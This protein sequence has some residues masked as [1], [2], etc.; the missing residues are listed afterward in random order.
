MLYHDAENYDEFILDYDAQSCVVNK[1]V[2]YN[3][4]ET[5]YVLDNPK[6]IEY[7]Y[8]RIELT[9]GDYAIEVLS[10]SNVYLFVRLMA[11]NIY[12]T[13]FATKAEL[14]SEISQ[15]AEEIGL[16]V[17]KKLTNYSTT[18]QMNSAIS[19]KANEITSSVSET[20][21]TKTNATT[22]YSK[23]TQTA[24]SLQSQISVNDTDISTIKQSVNE[25]NIEVGKKYNTSDFTNAKITA[26]IND[27]TSS[28]LI[29]AN[30]IN[31]SGYLTISSAS[32]TY[33][34]KSGL[35]GGTTTI[36]GNC[37]T[38]GT[39]DASKV[40]VKNLNASN[41][42]SGTISASKIS[43]GSLNLTGTSTTITSTNF[44]VDKNGNITANSGTIGGFSISGHKL[45]STNNTAGISSSTHDGNPV[46]WAGYGDP[47][48]T[49]DWINIIPFYVTNRGHLKATN[50]TISGIITATS[51][52]FDNCTI[53]NTCSVPASTITGVLASGNIPNISA[54]K[55]TSGTLSGITISG[56]KINA[57]SISAMTV[58]SDIVTVNNSITGHYEI[59]DYKGKSTTVTT[60]DGKTLQFVGGILVSVS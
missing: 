25:V 50:A 56:G 20:Y 35:S 47:Y 43:G 57:S 11:Q 10:Y 12:T 41:I 36:N 54:N 29:N 33:A 52:T 8:P 30:K 27:G 32:N 6:T 40:T 16:S 51:G 58:S 15:T 2:G 53:K 60:T 3:A 17:D 59:G 38:T 13:Q 42:T 14:N 34:T 5:T 18:T 23:L 26:K 45:K 49:D 28:V 21:E 55:I 31:L 37:I 4:D 46:F 24:N 48:L 1:R 9:D 44:S 7:E 22:N 39:I 19:V